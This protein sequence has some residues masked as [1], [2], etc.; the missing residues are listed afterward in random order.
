M[1]SPPPKNFTQ[2]SAFGPLVSP[3]QFEVLGTHLEGKRENGGIFTFFQRA[4]I[5][6]LP[7]TSAKE[8]TLLPYVSLSVRLFVCLSAG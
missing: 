4:R 2:L 3:S 1:L 5:L 6:P 7:V 8:V